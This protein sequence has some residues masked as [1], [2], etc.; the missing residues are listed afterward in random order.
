MTAGTKHLYILRALKKCESQNTNVARL[1][2]NPHELR[3]ITVQW[4]GDM[5][6]VFASRF[7]KR[8]PDEPPSTR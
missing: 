2:S 1:D 8:L 4:S 7:R 5:A 3:V 6:G